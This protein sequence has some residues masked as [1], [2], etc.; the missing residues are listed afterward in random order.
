MSFDA[1]ARPWAGRRDRVWRSDGKRDLEGSGHLYH[2]TQR[3]TVRCP[4]TGVARRCRPGCASQR[5]VLPFPDRRSP[6]RPGTSPDRHIR[7]QASSIS[8]RCTARTRSTTSATRCSTTA[9]MASRPL[10]ATCWTAPATGQAHSA[11][12]PTMPRSRHKQSRS[13]SAT[14]PSP[15]GV[16]RPTP[17]RSPP[18]SDTCSTARS[19]RTVTAEAFA[20]RLPSSRDAGRRG[21]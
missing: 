1:T 10:S 13:A 6:A 9:K 12:P 21:G 20:R 18:G 7:T 2:G 19:R 11:R 17:P 8:G 16:A 4:S 15:A 5:E 3:T 14:S